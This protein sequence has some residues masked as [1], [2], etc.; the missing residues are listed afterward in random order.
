[1]ARPLVSLPARYP[2]KAKPLTAAAVA[3]MRPGKDR[4]EVPD[5]GCPGLYLLIQPSGAKGWALRYRR[6]DGRPAKLV[7]GSAFAKAA[8]TKE[9]DTIPAI[10]GHHTLAAAHRL[11]TALRHE[12]AQGRDPAAVHL[13]AKTEQRSAA[14]AATSN[15]FAAAAQDFIEGHAR[16][17]VR[18]WPELARLLGL[19]PDSL[20]PIP[21][22]LAD[23]WAERPVAEIDGHDIHSVVDEARRVGVP[24]LERRTDG[25]SEPRARKMFGVLSKMF[26]WLIRDRRVTTNPCISV[27]RPEI[28]KARDRVLG[29]SEIVRFW[30]AT[31]AAGEPYTA[32]LRLLLLTGCRLNEVAGM[33]HREIEG[34]QWLI[35]GERTKN[36]RA[37]VVPLPVLARDLI[38]SVKRIEGCPYMFSTTGRSPVS[39]WSKLKDRL[40][41]AM[42]PATPWVLHDLRR[43]AATGMAEIGIAPHI[44]EAVLNHISGARAGVAGTYNRAAYA[45]EKK[46]ALERWAA[47]I[48][49][50]VSGRAA[51]VT[52]LRA[53]TRARQ[54]KQ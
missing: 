43:T 40:D 37:H 24:G 48:E 36:H 5:A 3:K 49:G 31:D 10:G 2:T 30:S 44:V 52:P 6:P 27:A 13:K 23:R 39:G 46:A 25:D 47:H 33:R 20:A 51:T 53:R 17:K 29:N 11:V 1:M 16:R 50:L 42:K 9:P 26:A 8:D 32:L 45:P 4:R 12:I 21:K 14:S 7:L 35:P 19:E 18:R 34:D 38:D 54:N 22:G 41:A 15:T 28:P